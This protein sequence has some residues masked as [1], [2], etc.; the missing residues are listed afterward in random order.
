MRG[1]S[2]KE[3]SLET[4]VWQ[5]REILRKTSKRSPP[6]NQG[7]SVN[8]GRLP[9]TTDSVHNDGQKTDKQVAQTMLTVSETTKSPILTE[10]LCIK[11][12][13]QC[14]QIAYVQVI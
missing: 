1:Y 7:K 11:V 10:L 14:L 4:A 13:H 2:E 3:D 8:V 5:K 6:E 12:P 9:T